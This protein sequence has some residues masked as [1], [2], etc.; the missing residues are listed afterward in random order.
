MFV[1]DESRSTL[2]ARSK[3]MGIDLEPLITSGNLTVQQI[4]PAELSPGEFAHQIRHSW[5]T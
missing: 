3:G 5:K 4:D 2:L 1:F